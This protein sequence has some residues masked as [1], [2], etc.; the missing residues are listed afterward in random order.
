MSKDFITEAVE[1]PSEL[2][3]DVLRGEESWVARNSI[4]LP[5]AEPFKLVAGRM[6]IEYVGPIDLRMKSPYRVNR[7]RV[8]SSIVVGYVISINA[9]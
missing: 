9:G 8:T 4:R 7:S 1:L 6:D 5:A 3:A 2:P